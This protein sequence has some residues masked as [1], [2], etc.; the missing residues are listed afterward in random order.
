MRDGFVRE[1][2]RALVV[3]RRTV[4]ELMKALVGKKRECCHEPE[5][6]L[7]PADTF[8]CAFCSASQSSSFPKMQHMLSIGI[9][10]R[11]VART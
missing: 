9:K 6:Y 4:P 7:F 1:K 8:C 5:A 2:N 10:R 11:R 3:V